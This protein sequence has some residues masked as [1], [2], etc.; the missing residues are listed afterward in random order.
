MK[1]SS[2]NSTM[3]VELLVPLLAIVLLLGTGCA[4]NPHAKA[5]PPPP[6]EEIRAHLGTIGLLGAGDLTNSLL[7]KPLSTGAA[8]AAGAGMGALWGL[9]AGAEVGRAGGGPGVV[10]MVLVWSV[11]VPVGT[12]VGAAIGNMEGMPV[13]KRQEAENRLHL[14]VIET[15]VQHRLQ[16]Q[17]LQLVHQRTQ[18]TVVPLDDHGLTG[19]ADTN[20]VVD[21]ILEVTVLN[22][23]LSGVR[24]SSAPLAAFLQVRVRLVRARNGEELYSHTWVPRSGSLTFEKWAD[25]NAR[26]LR[27]ELPKMI[28]P[29]AESIVEELFVVYEPKQPDK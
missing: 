7:Q 5:F 9:V 29:L 6:S 27:E 26:P 19:S 8:T 12:L 21:T 24:D 16:D 3:L 18:E 14:A 11:A 17:V 22:A 28:R 1:P 25:D 15:D 13:R 20:Q 10:A 23:G 2:G 4:N